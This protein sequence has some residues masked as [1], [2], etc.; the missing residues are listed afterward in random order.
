MRTA[1]TA[2]SLHGHLGRWDRE[3][4]GWLSRVL[5]C[6]DGEHNTDRDDLL[7]SLR[8]FEALSDVELSSLAEQKRSQT[9]GTDL[10]L[11]KYNLPYLGSN[12]HIL[13]SFPPVVQRKILEVRA[14]LEMLN[15]MIDQTRDYVPMTFD[16]NMSVENRL[17]LE[18]NIERTYQHIGQRLRYLCDLVGEIYG[19]QG[20]SDGRRRTTLA[21]RSPSP[22]IY[23]PHP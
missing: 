11:R 20:T 19:E 13:A 2:Y 15:E 9:E 22:P 17:A 7:S 3:F 4:F 6:Y 1:M 12:I 14:Q 23:Q 8:K 21:R 16:A 10:G 5:E 18:G